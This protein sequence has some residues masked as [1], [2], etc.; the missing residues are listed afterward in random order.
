MN[1]SARSLT[2]KSVTANS[3]ALSYSSDDYRGPRQR[4]PV[5]PIFTRNG[6]P[7]GQGRGYLA[8]TLPAPTVRPHAATCYFLEV[9]PWEVAVCALGPPFPV[10]LSAPGT[11]C[12]GIGCH[13]SPRGPPGDGAAEGGRSLDPGWPCGAEPPKLPAPGVLTREAPQ[14]AGKLCDLGAPDTYS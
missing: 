13:L 6:T 7:C 4:L 5:V 1:S 10:L 2:K 14:R 11:Y 9:S 12:P 8:A 3:D